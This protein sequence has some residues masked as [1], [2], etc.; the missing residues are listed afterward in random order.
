[1]KKEWRTALAGVL[2]R[3]P[4]L[5]SQVV[6]EGERKNRPDLLPLMIKTG[7]EIVRGGD[8][9]STHDDKVWSHKGVIA[10]FGVM[11]YG[12]GRQ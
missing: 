1:M 2:E 12:E 11:V 3:L 7:H 5:G 10:E 4:V 9:S 8:N 6:G